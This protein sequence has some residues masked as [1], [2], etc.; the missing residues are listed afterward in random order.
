M[1]SLSFQKIKFSLIFFIKK[2]RAKNHII[3]VKT[4][5][6]QLGFCCEVK[7]RSRGPN[8]NISKVKVL[9]GIGRLSRFDPE[10]SQLFI[11]CQ[12]GLDF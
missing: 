3:F 7:S 10:T 2:N 11:T 5:I 8:F 4:T 9:T 6:T 1:G 12:L